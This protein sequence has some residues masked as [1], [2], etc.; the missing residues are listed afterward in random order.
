MRRKQLIVA[1][2]RWWSIFSPWERIRRG[3]GSRLCAKCS[4]KRSGP[5]LRRCQEMKKE[6]WRARA[7]RKASQQM[8][9]PAPGVYNESTP[10]S[11]VR[12]NLILIGFGVQLVCGGA[13]NFGASNGRKKKSVQL[14]KP[15][16]ASD[17]GG[18]K[19]VNLESLLA[20]GKR[21]NSQGTRAPLKAEAI[22]RKVASSEETEGR[23]VEEEKVKE[24]ECEVR[25]KEM[26]EE[27][28]QRAHHKSVY[29]E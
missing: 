3:L 26:A 15:R 20:R 28:L 11:Q 2:R 19:F 13:G 1:R 12:L 23:E 16:V 21:R 8:V 14:F 9:L 24:K 6:E 4:S 5:L 27:E 22:R 7:K 29:V 17:G 10:A 18:C 25:R